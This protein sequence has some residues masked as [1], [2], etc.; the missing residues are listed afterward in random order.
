MSTWRYFKP[1]EVDGLDAELVSKLDTARH[2]AGIPFIITSG[3]RTPEENERAMGVDGSAH[4][5]GLAVDIR[6]FDSEGRYKMVSGLLQAGFKRIGIY[7]LHCHADIS[8]ELPT[9]RIWIGESH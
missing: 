4:V 5:K 9:P 8:E 3:K 2:V 7:N 1:E 6:C